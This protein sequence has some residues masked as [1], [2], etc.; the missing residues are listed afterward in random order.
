V[1]FLWLE[2]QRSEANPRKG[3]EKVWNKSSACNDNNKNQETKKIQPDIRPN[4]KETAF[5]LFDKPTIEQKTLLELGV[6]SCQVQKFSL[7]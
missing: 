5:T 3:H 7:L 1:P 2:L 4:H 6:R